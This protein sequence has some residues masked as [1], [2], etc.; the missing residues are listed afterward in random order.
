[1]V[2]N[3]KL[4][5]IHTIFDCCENTEMHDKVGEEDIEL[6]TYCNVAESS[7]IYGCGKNRNTEDNLNTDK[8]DSFKVIVNLLVT[9]KIVLL[10]VL[11]SLGLKDS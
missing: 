1:M 8:E 3:Y 11:I 6:Q 4:T 5:H 7:Y 2:K 10:F 9:N